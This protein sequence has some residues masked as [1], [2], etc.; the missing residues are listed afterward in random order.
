MKRIKVCTGIT[1]YLKGIEHKSVKEKTKVMAV[2]KERTDGKATQEA[3]VNV[4]V[5]SYITV[6]SYSTIHKKFINN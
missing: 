1:Q 3:E 6:K 2:L 4:R 5:E